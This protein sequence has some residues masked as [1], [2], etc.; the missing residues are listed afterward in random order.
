MLDYLR[1]K[2]SYGAGKKTSPADSKKSNYLTGKIKGSLKNP[3]LCLGLAALFLL[4]IALMGC[5]GPAEKVLPDKS[6]FHLLEESEKDALFIDSTK[7]SLPESPEFILVDNFML[8]AISPPVTFSSQ[9]LGSL[10]AGYEEEDVKMVITEYIVEEGDSLLSLAAKF[11]ISLKTILWT[12]D[13]TEKSIIK[14]GDKLVILPVSGVIHHVKDKDTISGVAQTYKV[15]IDEIIVFNHL[16]EGGRIYVGDILIVPNGTMPA[17]SVAPVSVPLASSY[18]FVPV[19]SPYKITQGL[20]WYNAIDFSHEGSACSKPIYAAAG[21]TVL[22]VQ[23]TSSTS[24]W[25]FGGA[26]NHITILHPNGVVTMYGHISASFVNPEEQVFQ[27]QIIA[28]IG[29]Q[30]GTPGAG[31]STGCHLHFGVT[32]AKNPFAR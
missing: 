11:N 13:L 1:S 9:V 14:P 27:G 19:S 28:L 12:N 3:P 30:P 22:K 24:R 18:F 6:D 8:K 10:V 15:E 32:G 17:P 29:G 16:S 4:F 2:F 21:G 23:L 20:H 7:I 31:L 25:A 26:G 5:S